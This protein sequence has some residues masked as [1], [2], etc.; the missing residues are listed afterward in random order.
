MIKFYKCK[1]TD[2]R[3][4]VDVDAD[5]IKKVIALIGTVKEMHNLGIIYA[6]AENRKN[7]WLKWIILPS[8][9]YDAG[10]IWKQKE[11]FVYDTL[12]DAKR[13]LLKEV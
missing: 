13:I 8:E 4:A 10:T 5:G 12:A 7:N 9:E 1:D 3:K 11:S 6:Q 2:V